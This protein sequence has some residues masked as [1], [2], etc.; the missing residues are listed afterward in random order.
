M[1]TKIEARQVLDTS[2][3]DSSKSQAVHLHGAKCEQGDDGHLLAL[4]KMKPA[5]FDGRQCEDGAVDQ[6]MRKDGREEEGGFA[7]VT[8]LSLCLKGL[9]PKG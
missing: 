7:N 3:R 8:L 4:W 1:R 6:D 9:F 2:Q 5:D